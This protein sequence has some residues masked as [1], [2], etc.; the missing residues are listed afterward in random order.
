[1]VSRPCEGC[2]WLAPKVEQDRVVER[3]EVWVGESGEG[4]LGCGHQDEHCR[5]CGGWGGSGW[6]FFPLCPPVC[7]HQ[8]ENQFGGVKK[9]LF[10]GHVGDHEWAVVCC[11]GCGVGWWDC[12]KWQEDCHRPAP[13]LPTPP[14]PPSLLSLPPCPPCR[15]RAR[16]DAPT[17]EAWARAAVAQI[18]YETSATPFWAHGLQAALIRSA[19]AWLI[20]RQVMRLHQGFRAAFYRRQARQAAEEARAAAAEAAGGGADGAPDSP[21]KYELRRRK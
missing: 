5:V 18:G 10:H 13:S 6:G 14:G 12:G 16:L 11:A 1:M 2:A 4:L 17:P 9:K 8:G 15:R 7:G 19:P 21:T 3:V 20:N